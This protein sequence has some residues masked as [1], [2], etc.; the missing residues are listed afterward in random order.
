MEEVALTLS[1]RI[2]RWT[3]VPGVVALTALTPVF[4]LAQTMPSEQ[5]GA[6]AEQTTAPSTMV[7]QTVG[8]GSG[9]TFL[10][11]EI[12]LIPGVGRSFDEGGPGIR[13]DRFV[14]DD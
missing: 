13:I 2:A 5:S 12:D 8:G 10:F 9:P 11:P 1:S 7:H 3:I 14:E 4:A 6:P